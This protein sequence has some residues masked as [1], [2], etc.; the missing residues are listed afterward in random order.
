MICNKR[1]LAAVFGVSEETLTRWAKL[2]CPVEEK[3]RG[4]QGSRY[5]TAKVYA[6][7]LA[8]AERPHE[9]ADLENER[10]R[11]VRTQREL[12]E[13]DLEERRKE[14]VRVSDVIRHLANLFADIKSILTAMPSIAAP[15]VAAPGRAAEAQAILRKHVDACLNALA[16][17]VEKYATAAAA[18]EEQ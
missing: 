3:G 13:L 17:A 5:D 2:G 4:T 1:E 9:P 18:T 6:W 14:L 8:L 16:D 15:Q 12:A 7:R 11:L 10:T